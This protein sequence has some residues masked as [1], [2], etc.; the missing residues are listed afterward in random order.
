MM[1]HIGKP[2]SGPPLEGSGAEVAASGGRLV[3][4]EEIVA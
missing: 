3:G 4:T 2:I 1:I